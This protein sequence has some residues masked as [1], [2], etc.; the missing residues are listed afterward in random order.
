MKDTCE[1]SFNESSFRYA[2]R[3][4]TGEEKLC[5]D[6]FRIK[7]AETNQEK[8]EKT[9]NNTEAK[10]VNEMKVCSIPLLQRKFNM[11]YQEAVEFKRILK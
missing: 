11:S 4:R 2:R 10:K 5:N 9:K 6:C 1:S 7:H 3:L 8:R